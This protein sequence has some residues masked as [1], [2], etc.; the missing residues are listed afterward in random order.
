M[1]GADVKD[2]GE[3]VAC[4]SCGTQVL[5]KKMIPLLADGGGIRY[6]CVDC[7]RALRPASVTESSAAG[8]SA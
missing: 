4:P 8:H 7:A 1:A 6:V 2:A 5:Q 3:E